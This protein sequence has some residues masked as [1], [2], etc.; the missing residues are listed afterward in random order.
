[1]TDIS[2]AKAIVRKQ[3]FAKR[4]IAHQNADDAIANTHLQ[5]ALPI[6]GDAHVFAAYM[7]IQ[8]EISPMSTMEW[9][10][11]QGKSVCVPV[12]LGAGQALE[13]HQWTPETVMIKGAFGA[14][15]PKDG[16]ALRPDVVITP[17][18][19]FDMSGYRLGYGGGFYDRSF[20][21]LAATG[22]VAAVG[23]AYQGQEL[24]SVPTE[25]TDHRLDVMVT[26]QGAVWF[27]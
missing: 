6:L 17:L 26:E 2:Q 1:M 3:A 22:S 8:T 13:F 21:E 11:A 27:E 19:A 4:K 10:V 18:V 23:F 12:I 14:A 25:S 20:E 7:P 9:L 16:T 24:P 5:A 15:I